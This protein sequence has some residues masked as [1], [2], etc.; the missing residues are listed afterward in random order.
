ML[1]SVQTKNLKQWLPFIVWVMLIFAVS[2]IPRLSGDEF[3]LLRWS[4]KI[5]HFLEYLVSNHLNLLVLVYEKISFFIT[6][7]YILFEN[8]L[9]L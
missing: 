1:S 8:F 9:L 4:D 3:G 7:K 6:S 5:A 2:S